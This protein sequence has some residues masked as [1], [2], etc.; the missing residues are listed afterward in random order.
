MTPA[1]ETSKEQLYRLGLRKKTAYKAT[2]PV[3]P[4][5]A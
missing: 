3:V 5:N 1:F 2:K 4:G